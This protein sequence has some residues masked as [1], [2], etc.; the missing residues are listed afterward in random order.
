MTRFC[1]KRRHTLSGKLVMLFVAMALLTAV[2]LAITLSWALNDHFESGIRPHLQLYMEYLKHDLGSPPQQ[3]KAQ[4]LADR[5]GLEIYYLGDKPWSTSDKMITLDEIRF[6][7]TFQHDDIRFSIG[8]DRQYEYLV[9]HHPD[10]NLVLAV[11][12]KRDA[13]RK[14]IVVVV[15]LLMLLLLYQAIRLLFS[16]IKQLNDGIQRIGA[17]E[18]D[19]RLTIQRKDEL[20]SLANS[21]NEMATEIQKML[22]AKRQLLL[23]ISHELRTPVTRA[24]LITEMLE[25]RQSA[26]E[27]Q[28]ELNEMDSIIN[29]LLE[30]ERLRDRHK[31]LNLAQSNLTSLV[32]KVIDEYFSDRE[33]ITQWHDE[34]IIN[35]DATRIR[36]L[37]KNLLDNALRYSTTDQPPH[38]SISDDKNSVTLVVSDSGPGIDPQHIPHICEP[39]YRA[40]AAR[41]RE[42][43]GYGLGL[44]LCKMIVE[45]H[46][47]KLTIESVPGKG[48]DIK[49]TIP[50]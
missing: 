6:K 40:D 18:L 31:A 28:Q 12:Q 16:P 30:S 43:G 38:L 19:Y 37:I 13:W 35:I 29:E 39:F 9:T 20:G 17:G 1:R 15:I 23:A 42:T 10:Y 34:V 33:I 4:Q 32:Q 22:D 14:L 24:K 47:G 49:V 36:L 3:Q 25:D 11:P 46:H 27:L 50:R 2:V 48:C 26:K 5:L 8:H 41:Q 21:I 45:A 44:Y 7:R